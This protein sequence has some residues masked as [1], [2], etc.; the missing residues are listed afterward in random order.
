M[1][2]L[3]NLVLSALFLSL[4]ACG[5][6]LRGSVNLAENLKT[7]YVQGLDL[8]SD[9]GRTLKN[10]L[11]SNGVNVIEQYQKGA[12]VLTILEQ[13]IDRRVLSV[14]GSSAKVSEYELLGM[15]K[16]KVS[17]DTGRVLV[18]EDKVDAVRDY[19]FDENQVL[20]KAEEENALR[21]ELQQQLV[22]NL[23]RR[24]AAVK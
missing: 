11:V 3:S 12:A 24:L 13:R 14:S 21:K 17:D 5:F 23:L 10:N 15:I 8:K 18:A 19:R 2:Y 9:L 16:Y 6:H 1:R 7:M 20:A 4:V 22:Q